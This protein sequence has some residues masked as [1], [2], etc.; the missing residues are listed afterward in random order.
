M[1]STKVQTSPLAI[2]TGAAGFLGRHAAR[3]LKNAG[4]DVVGL[5]INTIP[6]D[7]YVWTGMSR[8]YK[9]SI[10]AKA[11]KEIID[12]EG[13]PA[14]VFHAAGGASVSLSWRDPE[15]DRCNTFLG[16]QALLDG[17]AHLGNSVRLIFASSAAVYGDQPSQPI[18]EDADY[19]PISPYG[20]HKM[21]AEKACLAAARETSMPLFILRFFSLYGPYL[22]KQILWD[23]TQRLASNPSQ[24]QLGGHGNETR[25][26]L[27]VSDAASLVTLAAQSDRQDSVILNGGTGVATRIEDL[28]KAVVQEMGLATSISF[29]QQC[30]KGDPSHLV[31]ETSRALSFGFKPFHGLQQGLED[32]VT[33]A[34]S[35]AS[36][37]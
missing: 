9:T 18:P 4:Y 24:I 20:E 30:P 31:A 1:N 13:L 33:W 7:A 35:T 23:L 10:S 32:Y 22:R 28:A 3:A 34:K 19:S 25:D 27:H 26:F 11:I 16:T 5:D 37:L 36:K 15:S 29:S 17:I 14:V 6:N 8:Y 12:R 21:L 2:V